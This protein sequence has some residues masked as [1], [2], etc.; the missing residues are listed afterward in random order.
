MHRPTPA[1]IILAAGASSRMK[2]SLEAMHSQGT[3]VKNSANDK[4]QQSPY[5]PTHK[6]LIP[7]NDNGHTAIDLL[8]D[9][10]VQAGISRV[11]MV[12]QPPG[13]AFKNHFEKKRAELG[14]P[15]YSNPSDP[16][17]ITLDFAFQKIPQGREKPLGTAD[18]LQQCMEQFPELHQEEFMVCNADNLYT[19]DAFQALIQAKSPNALIG[20]DRNGLEFPLEK[21]R[22]FA[23]LNSDAQNFMID[24]LEKPDQEATQ[25]LLDQ[26]QQLNVSMNLWKFKGADLWNAL[27]LCPVHPERQEKELPAAVKLMITGGHAKIL[28]IPRK[29]HVP[30]LTQASDINSVRLFLNQGNLDH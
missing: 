26:G 15:Q 22:S 6:G 9:Q 30:D 27:L 2:K 10:A 23:L 4:N 3:M 11:I 28:V 1:L 13:N 7:L 14:G 12:I 20:Y 8:I 17:K 21:I 5:A 24:L 19:S 29:E 16:K 25:K 18:A